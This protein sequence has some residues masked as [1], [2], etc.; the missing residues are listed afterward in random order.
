MGR[1]GG[2]EAHLKDGLGGD[3]EVMAGE[4]G[5]DRDEMGELVG[6]WGRQPVTLVLL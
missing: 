4:L 6:V 1:A 5:E 3:G 2:A